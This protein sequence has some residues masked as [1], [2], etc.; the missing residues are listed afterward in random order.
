ML[1]FGFIWDMNSCPLGGSP[2]FVLCLPPIDTCKYGSRSPTFIDDLFHGLLS[3]CLA[4]VV[5]VV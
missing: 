3:G 1:T 5:Y 2:V 4:E